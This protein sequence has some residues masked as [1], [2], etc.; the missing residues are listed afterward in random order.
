MHKVIGEYVLYGLKEYEKIVNNIIA[1]L[2]LEEE[3]FD[4]K[5]ILTEALNNAVR[6][7]NCNDTA[8]PVFLRYALNAGVLRLDIED[9]GQGFAATDIKSEIGDDDL[10]SEDGRGLYLINCLA[11]KLECKKNVLT[12]KKYLGKRGEY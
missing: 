1:E 7:G 10:M 8:K 4:V 12:I 3:A 9:S 11:D 2:R 6:H 5:L